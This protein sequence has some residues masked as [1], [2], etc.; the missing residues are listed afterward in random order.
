MS[1]SIRE[2]LPDQHPLQTERVRTAADAIY[3]WNYEP[4]IDQLRTLYANA[5]DRQWIA[6]K[7]LDWDTPIDRAA[8]SRTF[9]VGG[10]PVT[11]TEFWKTLSPDTQWQVARR[12]A[13]LMLSTF[14]HGEQGAL[15][16]ASQLVSA[17]PHM[18][19]KFYASTQTMDE[20][21]HVE[22]FAAY[23]RKL[24]EVYPITSGLRAIL[25]AILSNDNWMMKAVGMNIVLEGLALYSFRDMRNQTEEPLLKKLLTYVARDEARH[26][27]YGIKYLSSVV[28][29]L[30]DDEKAAIEDFAFE[31]A[32]QLIDQRTGN[33][34]RGDMLALWGDAGVD[35]KEAI[36]ALIKERALIQSSIRKK[37]GSMGPVHGFVV[38]TLASIGLFS[39]RIRGHFKEMW[40]ANLGVETAERMAREDAILPTDLDEWVDA[41]YES[42]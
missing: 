30:D 39:D 8:F 14:L 41:G 32:R 33:S 38:P 22:V 4:E 21:R 18:D 6:M 7:D 2:S 19:G 3:N 10:I 16:T 31:A 35:P 17:V 34:M 20:A 12:T 24:G 23:V 1:S 15:M 25:D 42:L 37:G 5:L 28:P 27:G 11:R 40:G 9:A 29:T 13:A 36:T 26:T